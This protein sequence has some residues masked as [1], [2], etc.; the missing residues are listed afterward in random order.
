MVPSD[1]TKH[2]NQFFIPSSVS[3]TLHLVAHVFFCGTRNTYETRP[4]VMLGAYDVH[5]TAA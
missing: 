2:E 3:N 4:V 5:P 1:V